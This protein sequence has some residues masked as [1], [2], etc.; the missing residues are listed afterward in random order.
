M[1]N[2]ISKL[3]GPYFSFLLSEPDEIWERRGKVRRIVGIKAEYFHHP[4]ALVLPNCLIS[5]VTTSFE[6]SHPK[7]NYYGY[8]VYH[9]ETLE[10]LI[11]ELKLQITAIESCKDR[12][13]FGRVLT[14]LFVIDC[15]DCLGGWQKHWPEIKQQSVEAVNKV[16]FL[17]E[18]GKA[19]LKALLVLGV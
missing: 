1:T 13:E 11:E 5:L 7:F 12:E 3:N 2:L 8:T 19:E 18:K 16:I 4:D 14:E 6:K 17:A 9:V 10:C 15:S